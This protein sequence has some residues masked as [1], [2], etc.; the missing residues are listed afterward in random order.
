MSYFL[1]SHSNQ[2]SL[3]SNGCK[4][5]FLLS[6]RT[7]I[8]LQKITGEKLVILWQNH[9]SATCVVRLWNYGVSAML[10]FWR[11]KAFKI[12]S[13]QK[14]SIR[15]IRPWK[16]NPTNCSPQ[17]A[18]MASTWTEVP[19]NGTKGLGT[20]NVGS[21]TWP[22]VQWL[23]ISIIVISALF[24]GNQIKKSLSWWLEYSEAVWQDSFQYY[25]ALQ[26]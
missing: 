19:S 22:H 17:A 8:S 18:Q 14:N 23:K 6:L 24:T 13:L 26:R 12:K 15:K 5:H 11:T 16:V 3:W 4:V 25:I 20:L 7:T 10:R 21:G 9:L 2:A 1:N